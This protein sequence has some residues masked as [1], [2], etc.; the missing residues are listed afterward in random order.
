VYGAEKGAAK[1]D[2]VLNVAVAGALERGAFDGALARWL[3]GA[4]ASAA[5]GSLVRSLSLPPHVRTVAVGGAT[6]GGS[7]K[8]PLAIACATELAGRGARV[9][10]VGHG[11]RGRVRGGGD[12]SDTRIVRADDAL[13]DVGD[14]AL[15][16]AR[17]L[18]PGACAVVGPTRAAALDFAARFADVVV[19]DG[20]AQ[21]SPVRASLALLAVDANEPWGRAVA[22]PPRGDLVAPR[23]VLLAACDAVVRVGCDRRADP[24]ASVLEAELGKIG[25][26]RATTPRQWH[27]A[28]PR[29]RGAWLRD[30]AAYSRPASLLTWADLREMRV[31]LVSAMARP[32]RVA[33]DL[34]AHGVEPV[35]CFRAPDHGPIGPAMVRA[36]RLAVRTKRVDLWLATAKCAL[37]LERLA[38]GGTPRNTSD[39]LG[40]P[41]AT[42]EYSLAPGAAL[43]ASLRAIGAP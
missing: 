13:D 25:S 5:R 9:V 36:C 26:D 28:V 19:F 43:C 11:Y 37:H 8:T 12:G 27:V 29:A 6:L 32:I 42:L 40:A 22:S 3:E 10:L 2:P 41:T 38:V 31:G 1:L 35:V 7:G 30:V 16:A 34:S 14:E 39:I 15:L 17:Q 4:W 24:G 23:S 33:R 20:V 21:T 18:P